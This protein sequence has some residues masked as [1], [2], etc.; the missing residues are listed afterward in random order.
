MTTLDED[1]PEE[2]WIRSTKPTKEMLV[3]MYPDLGDGESIESYVKTMS[4]VT[5]KAVEA[6]CFTNKT[7]GNYIH[8]TKS[9][10]HMNYI[11]P[12]VATRCH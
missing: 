8:L 4:K 12:S 11:L 5:V 3:L 7:L 2:F 10:I 6:T 9:P 1:A